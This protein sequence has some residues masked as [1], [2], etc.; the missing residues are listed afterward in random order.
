MR[1][2]WSRGGRASKAQVGNAWYVGEGDALFR[3][4]AGHVQPG[5]YSVSR[6]AFEV[7]DGG[8]VAM[9]VYE[10]GEEHKATS[11]DAC[12]VCAVTGLGNEPVGDVYG[13]GTLYLIAVEDSHVL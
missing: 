13:A 11:I 1:T 10:A 4:E 3:R 9:C 5:C 12:G 2:T 6:K 8:W 7:R